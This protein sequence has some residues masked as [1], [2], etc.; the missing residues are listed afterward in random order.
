MA[1]I[2][3]MTS[4]FGHQNYNQEIGPDGIPV[5]ENLGQM[6][7]Q[8][9]LHGGMQAF[10]AGNELGGPI[11][12]AFAGVGGAMLG[13]KNADKLYSDANRNRNT[14]IDNRNSSNVDAATLAALSGASTLPASTPTQIPTAN[15]PTQSTQATD[16]LT[17][18]GLA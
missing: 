8:G 7:G 1:G 9:A 4:N 6:Q 5:Q 14:A 18:L 3:E 16:Q 12:G 13:Y 2:E 17:S 11:V 10:K 15:E